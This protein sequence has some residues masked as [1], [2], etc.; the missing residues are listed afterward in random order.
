MSS[1]KTY[2]TVT[3]R[4][5]WTLNRFDRCVYCASKSEARKWAKNLYGAHNKIVSIREG[6]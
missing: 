2:F 6:L 3:L 4:R 1:T 5:K